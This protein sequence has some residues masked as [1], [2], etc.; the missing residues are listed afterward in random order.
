MLELKL[1]GTALQLTKGTYKESFKNVDRVNTSEG[2]HTLRAVTR[3]GIPTLN[4]SYTCDGLEKA[5]LDNFAESSSLT[6]TI[7]SE[8]LQ[9]TTTWLCYMDGYSADLIIENGNERFYKVSF[10]LNDL[11]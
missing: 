7:F 9:A 11:S 3:T 8:R 10:N 1:N 2:G 5:R 4:C 6:A